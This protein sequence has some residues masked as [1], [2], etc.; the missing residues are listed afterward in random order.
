MIGYSA[1]ESG[2]LAPYDTE[3][4]K[5]VEMAID[6]VNAEDAAGG[7]ELELETK[8]NQSDAATSRQVARELVDSGADTLLC[9]ADADPAIP[10]ALIGQEE[11]LPTFSF[12]SAPSLV[13]AV[14]SA[15]ITYSPDNLVAAANAEFAYDQGWDSA[16]LIGSNDIAYTKLIPTYFQEAY[17]RLGGTVVGSSS[18]TLSQ[19]DFRSIATRIAGLDE[20]PDVIFT[21]AFPPDSTA[22]L[23]DLRAAGIEAPVL[24]TDG[25]DTPLFLKGAGDAARN[26]WYSVQGFATPGDT[27]TPM[28]EF[29]ERFNE[30]TGSYPESTF[31]ALGYDTIKVLAAALA[32]AGTDEGSAVIASL[33][34]IPP[35]PGAAGSLG[36]ADGHLPTKEITFV[37]VGED[38]SLSEAGVVTPSFVPDPQ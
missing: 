30:T 2:W 4:L 27:S 3:Y 6:E 38:G 24:T 31:P 14:P 29:Y 10:C 12:A 16:Y 34:S 26:V 19:G 13:L 35:V 17:E 9:T 25:N 21:P 7:Y 36:F 28:G 15:F 1:A 22:L 37:A 8:D 20:T 18:F 32:D 11:G 5:G 23:R 33:E